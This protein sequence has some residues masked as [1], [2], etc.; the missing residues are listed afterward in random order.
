MCNYIKLC[1]WHESD[2]KN[3]IWETKYKCDDVLISP[4]F[5]LLDIIEVH[6]KHMWS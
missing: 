6:M 3:K 5:L 2:Y 1:E 4:Y